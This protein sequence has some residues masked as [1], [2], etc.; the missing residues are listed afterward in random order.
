MS[1]LLGIISAVLVFGSLGGYGYYAYLYTPTLSITAATYHTE[2][3]APAPGSGAW[4]G[5]R[6]DPVPT[7]GPES[8]A[9]L[10]DGMPD[11]LAMTALLLSGH[12][13]RLAAHFADWRARFETETGAERLLEIGVASFAIPDAGLTDALQAWTRATPKSAAAWTALGAHLAS[14]V[15]RYRAPLSGPDAEPSVAVLSDRLKS[16]RA[17]LDHAIAL[18]PQFG[19]AHGT[20]ITIARL[21]TSPEQ[22]VAMMEAAIEGCPRCM[23]PRWAFV[24]TMTPEWGGSE[25]ALKLAAKAARAARELNDRFA[26]L[27]G[28][29]AFVQ[30]GRS[31]RDGKTR[32]AIRWASRALRAG[33]HPSFFR[34][35]ARARMAASKPKFEAA[36]KDLDA[37][38]ALDPQNPFT[39]A[40]RG[41]ALLHS[42]EPRPAA[43]DLRLALQ[44]DPTEPT[45]NQASDA[46]VKWSIHLARQ[47][48]HGDQPDAVKAVLSLGLEIAPDDVAL[49]C[50]YDFLTEHP[51]II[52]LR[53]LD[54]RALACERPD[55]VG[56][57]EGLQLL[58]LA[59][60]K[61]SLSRRLNDMLGIWNEYLSRHPNHRDARINRAR[62]YDM[63]GQ[64]G[65]A[66]AD[67]RIACELG[68]DLGCERAGF[69]P[70]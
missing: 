5:G 21:D 3:A 26:A 35:R 6:P 29:A 4:S 34:Q 1:R 12:Y 56:P 41:Q 65:R 51:W 11:R 7:V 45:A 27:R 68:S 9:L 43:E 31:R 38:L 37:A 28:F 47:L 36:I 50:W 63:M 22:R 66:R 16:A 24:H 57:R 49:G 33:E 19:P 58:V 44:V 52:G 59:D 10:A 64:R 69:N 13:P 32:A 2:E 40:L 42:G 54:F 17:A 67:A 30:S 60:E 18:D 70:F 20:R 8:P 53:A 25:A 61:R 62:I 14:F 39:L 55:D 48:W 23:S 46:F 15:S